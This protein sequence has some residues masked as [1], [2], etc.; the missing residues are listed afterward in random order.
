MPSHYTTHACHQNRQK[1]K[2]VEQRLL[3]KLLV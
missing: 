3:L 2:N 1:V